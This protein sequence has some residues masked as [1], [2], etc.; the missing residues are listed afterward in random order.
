MLLCPIEGVIWGP[1]IIELLFPKILI[2]GSPYESRGGELQVAGVVTGS[3]AGQRRPPGGVMPP[4]PPSAG[5]GKRGGYGMSPMRGR[6]VPPPH[7]GHPMYM[8]RLIH[9]I[10]NYHRYS[11]WFNSFFLQGS[12]IVG[13]F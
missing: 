4:M 9:F 12:H 11:I 8:V 1:G 2:P 7:F 5:R 13:K 3:W 10:S 6:G